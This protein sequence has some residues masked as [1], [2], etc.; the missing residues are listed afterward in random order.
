MVTELM[1]A[2]AGTLAALSK[3]RYS[4][5]LP[6]E[7][8]PGLAPLSSPVVDVGTVSVA[9]S[10]NAGTGIVTAK[11]TLAAARGERSL[12]SR[13]RQDLGDVILRGKYSIPLSMSILGTEILP[14]RPLY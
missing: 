10:A 9:T 5:E 3:Y 6:L 1:V 8:Q 13:P 7:T 14:S 2:A 11:R 12:A 4:S